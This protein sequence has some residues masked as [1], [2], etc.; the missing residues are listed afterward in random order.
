M[1][2]F[3]E[4]KL[5]KNCDQS[6]S[7]ENSFGSVKITL[8][9]VHT[10]YSLP[11]WQAVKLTSFAPWTCNVMP[12]IQFQIFFFVTY[13]C[14]LLRTVSKC[15]NWLTQLWRTSHFDNQI[16]FFPEFCW[17]KQLFL[18][19]YLGFDWSGWIDLIKN[20]ILIITG[21]VWPVSSDKLMKSALSF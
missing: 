20:E 17:T 12:F 19:Y 6:Y 8:G 14:R 21:M 15:Q 16:G 9:V 13:L 2:C 4:C 1:K 18:A 7:S 11:K 3:G 10:S 5:Q